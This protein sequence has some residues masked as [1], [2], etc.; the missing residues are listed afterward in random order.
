M[1]KN[2]WNYPLR[3]H[4]IVCDRTRALFA[5]LVHAFD[6]SHFCYF[7]VT[8]EGYSSCLSSR[9]D[10][11]EFYLYNQL[12]LHNPFLKHPTLIPKGVFF[13]RSVTDPEYRK[14]KSHAKTFGIEDSLVLTFKDEEVLKGFSFGLNVHEKNYTLFANEMPLIKR[15]C[16][17]FEKH[18]KKSLRELELVD[19]KPFLGPSFNQQNNAF[20]LSD[21]KRADLFHHLKLNFPKLSKREKECLTLYLQGETANSIAETL[22]LSHR[23]VGSYLENL[24]CKLNCNRN[25]ELIKKAQELQDYGLLLP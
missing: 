3:K 9:S 2:I 19:I 25:T 4:H 7:F 11:L 18:A 21:K 24:K 23:T 20:S 8:K 22:K 12:F 16:S 5:P 17:E 14:S 15:F 13:T 6:L 10:W 1:N